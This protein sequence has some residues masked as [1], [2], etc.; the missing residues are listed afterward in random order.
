MNTV[1]VPAQPQ[2][3]ATF[4]LSIQNLVDPTTGEQLAI[5][6]VTLYVNPS[7]LDFSYRKLINR[8]ETRA[9]IIEEHWGDELDIITV[10]GSTGAFFGDFGLTTAQRHESF[11]MINFQEILALYR[12]NA[13]LYDTNGAIIAQGDVVIIFDNYT[14]SGQFQNFS[15]DE[16]AESPFQFK[17]NFTFE[18]FDTQV[19]N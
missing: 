6:G 4:S 1:R 12:N 11:A 17:F 16:D 19:G 7:E 2:Y 14:I 13:C 9:A 3:T 5:P 15:F 18:A 8:Y 10:D